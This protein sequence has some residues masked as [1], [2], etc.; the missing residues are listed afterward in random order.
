MK[1]KILIFGNGQMGNLYK[2]YF[3]EKGYEIKIAKGDIT[4]YEDVESAIKDFNPTVVINSAA[5]TNLEWVSDNKL[6]AFNVNV[7]G[8]DNIAKVCDANEIYFV[9]LSS[10]CIFE[11]KDENDVKTEDSEPAPASYYAWTKVWS[12]QMIG[13]EK[14][15]NFKYLVMR[16]RQPISGEVNYKNMLVKFLT[17]TKFIETPNTGTVLEDLLDWTEELI[18]QRATGVVNVA[19]EGWTTPLHIAELLKKHV[20][21]DLPI[22]KISKEELDSFMPNK[23][24]DTVLA[25]DRLKELVKNVDTYEQRL[26]ETIKKLADNIK[27]ID[28]EELKIQLDKTMA[29]S[30]ARTKVNDVWSK[31]LD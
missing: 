23:R 16:P 21:P 12:E 11:S 13:F 14:S 5:K 29:Q 4:K 6:E 7:L 17:F 8:A 18:E 28:K 19:N 25:V 1:D 10:G 22:E 3:D 30:K 31:L 9:H 2:D 24:V 27:S 26:E 15:E 20:L